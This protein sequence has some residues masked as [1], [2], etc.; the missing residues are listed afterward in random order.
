MPNKRM[1]GNGISGTNNNK[2]INVRN[3]GIKFLIL[4]NSVLTDK[5]DIYPALYDK[6]ASIHYLID[7]EG[8]QT[9]FADESEQT[10]T[11]GRSWFRKS[12]SLNK[13][14]VNLMFVNS[15]Y[16]TYTQ[17]QKDKFK[18]Y[19]EDFK[20]RNP[21][22]DLKINLLGLGEVATL[23]K[24][25]VPE[26]EGKIFPRH[27]APGKLFFWDELAELGFGLFIPTTPEQK[28]ESWVS[29]ASSELEIKALQENLQNYGYALETSGKYD[30]ATKA[31]VTRFNQRYV[32]DPTQAIDASIWSKA[33]QISLDHI[34]QY[35]NEKNIAATQT[36]ILP[37]SLFNIPTAP[38]AD[39]D[40]VSQQTAS[41]SM[42]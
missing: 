15:G 13:T 37:S 17:E 31:W 34:Q 20:K 1:D 29:P 10:F 35:N 11:N 8:F 30:N 36:A 39:T 21:A 41:L 42:K 32:P 25:D 16:E 38:E 27:E 5:K 14:A 7:K 3:E 9:Q 40:K 28:G 22:I 4:T 24:K 12:N 33:S 23:T 26:G 2:T 6:G 18:A 19:L